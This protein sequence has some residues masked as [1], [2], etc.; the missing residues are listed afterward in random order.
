[1]SYNNFSVISN[2]QSDD[3]DITLALCYKLNSLSLEVLAGMETT[4][5]YKSI[6]SRYKLHSGIFD[7]VTMPF[8]SPKFSNILHYCNLQFVLIHTYQ[9]ILISTATY[10]SILYGKFG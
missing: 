4:L 7:L 3:K 10:T 6:I 8:I 9:Y 5:H 2:S 1:M